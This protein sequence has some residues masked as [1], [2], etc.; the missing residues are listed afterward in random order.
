MSSPERALRSPPIYA[1]PPPYSMCSLEECTQRE[2]DHELSEFECTAS[3]FRNAPH[4]RRIDGSLAVTKYRRSAAGTL[5]RAPRRFEHLEITWAHLR[6][7]LCHQSL[8]LHQ[9][10]KSLAYTV[11][12]VD[13]RIR[14]LQVDLVVL[15]LAAPRI[16]IQL[17]RYHLLV[18]YLLCQAPPNLVQPKFMQQA[19]WT[20]MSAYWKE[21]DH[22]NGIHDD[23]L[24][25]YT[26]LVHVASFLLAEQ[27][28]GGAWA[29]ADGGYSSILLKYRQYVSSKNTTSSTSGL[30]SKFN[31]AL[32]IASAAQAGY[33]RHLMVFLTK[34]NVSPF[35]ILCRLCMAPALPVIRLQLLQ[36]YN[37]AWM[38]R[39]KVSGVEMAR[40]LFLPSPQAAIEFCVTCGVPMEGDKLIL[41]AAPIV[42]PP[43]HVLT[44][45]R[46][47]D[48]FIF[49]HSIAGR[50]DEDGIMIPSANFIQKVILNDE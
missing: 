5:Q 50:H 45:T 32:D 19:L 24:L 44:L 10:P 16:H 36:Q 11:A 34:E 42:I 21:S 6:Y 37:K 7:I 43:G 25:C 15:Q 30:Y 18:L 9:R 33:Y 12:F 13:D 27:T 17:T 3:T 38:K 46:N 48:D 2:H 49:G 40:L 28:L 35:S 1:F 39:E 23:E 20:A 22:H 14:A 41:K 4:Q 47:E 29:D 31:L 8:H 26:A